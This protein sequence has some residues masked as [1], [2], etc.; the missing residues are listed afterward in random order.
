MKLT[1]KQFIQ[2]WNETKSPTR[3]AEDLGLTCRSIYKR[4]AA[5]ERK[6]GIN[7]D[8]PAPNSQKRGRAAMTPGN[9][10]REMQIDNGMVVVFSDAHFWPDHTTTAFKALLE[11]I[12]EFKPTAIV[13]NGDALDGASISRF[14]RMDWS[15]LPT[16]AEELE[17]CQHYMGEI[18][19]VAKGAKLFWPLGNHDARLEANIVEHLPAFEGVK[20]TTLKEYFPA[21]LPC[22]SFWVNKDTC[23]KHRW[24]GGFSAGRAN[25]LNSG[26]N[27]ITGHT[28]HLSVMPVSDYNGVRWGVQTGTLANPHSEQFSYCEDS[29]R[30]WR[31][32]FVMLTFERGQLLMP[33]LI[34]VWDEQEGEV[35]WRGKIYRV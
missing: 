33:E 1:D 28:H 8:C 24:K 11:M 15:K 9:M 21:W 14:P 27:M 30:D 26:V 18:E 6:Y 2:K 10:R 20:G 3:M 29:P 5:I 12:K 32:G 25:A 13:C 16:V 7:L 19:A 17:A 23:I 34:Q 4:R 22:W 35:Q 31:S